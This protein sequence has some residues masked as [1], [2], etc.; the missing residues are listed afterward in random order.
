MT[1]AKA[2]P[3]ALISYNERGGE[4]S[5][6]LFI[7]RNRGGIWSEPEPLGPMVNGPGA[8]FVGVF[9][10]NGSQLVFS[11][12]RSGVLSVWSVDTAPLVEAGVLRASDLLR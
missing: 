9:T 1:Y 5:D 10:P 8:D 4:G 7:S 12:T 11:S 2:L 6:D 3:A